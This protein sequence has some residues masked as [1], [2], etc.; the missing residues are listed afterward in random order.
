MP[1]GTITL[2]T[3]TQTGATNK[4]SAL[5]H[6]ELDSNFLFLQSGTGTPAPV[7]RT[8]NAKLG[9]HISVFDRIPVA[10][11]AGIQAGT[12]TTD[13]STYIQACIDALPLNGGCLYFPYGTYYIASTLNFFRT[14]Q[15]FSFRAEG[16]GMFGTK[17]M[18][19]GATSGTAVKIRKAVRFYFG[20]IRIATNVAAGT[21][22]GLQVTAEA[23][24]SDCGPGTFQSVLVSGFSENVSIGEDAGNSASELLFLSLE[25][26]SA[27]YGVIVRGANSLDCQFHN[28]AGSACGTVLEAAASGPDCVWVYGGSAS[29]STVQDF[30][31]REAGAYGIYGFRSE[32]AVR[33]C[34]F[35]PDAGAGSASPTTAEIRGCRVAT[36]SASDNRAI[37]LNKAG[38][39]SIECNTL[40]DGHVYIKSGNTVSGSLALK[41]NTIVSTIDLEIDASA[42]N[43]QIEKF[44]NSD[45]AGAGSFWTRG[46]YFVPTSNAGETTGPELELTDD[47]LGDVLADQWNTRVGSDGNCVAAAI[48]AS[49]AGG[50]I[51]MTTGTNATN[52]MATD[53]TLLEH[54][55]NWQ[56]DKGSLVME[57]RLRMNVTDIAIFFGFKDSVGTGALANS[58]M[59]F[60]L[61]AA[62][63][64]TSNSVDAFGV[65]Y[66][67]NA[68]TDNWWGVGVANN[69]DATKQN[70]A[71][72]PVANAWETW[73]I[74]YRGTSA[75]FY[76]NN[77]L[78]GSAMTGAVTASV[79]L[80]PSVCAFGR[81][82]SNR[83]IQVD[84]IRVRGN[85]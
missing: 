18:W 44:G 54:A 5:T 6:E 9:E 39:Y 53:G 65:L 10:L 59:P 78:I 35:G 26:S 81:N 64:L 79:A 52:D 16:D 72:A 27:T 56:P 24:S 42:F 57:I 29:N 15:V 12:E 48:L 40:S 31:F 66:D 61:A 50:V 7:A 30:A 28:L 75:Y 62:D 74:E 51:Q 60:T 85:R 4:G 11:Q 19:N 71:V 41:H 8:V 25:T 73:R 68:A 49:Q 67:V 34:T 23:L 80:T 47:F 58:D 45:T 82:S 3:T 38:H 83:N 77:A 36:T 17:I 70:F 20:H 55:R 13:V 46:E 76:R 63:A 22:K 84:Y 14:G 1:A 2:R 43:W 69:V 33:F 37:R 32:G 21:S